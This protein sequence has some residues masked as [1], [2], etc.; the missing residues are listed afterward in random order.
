MIELR[1]VSFA[2]ENA[3][4]VNGL[5]EVS[6]RIPDGQAVLLCGES[7]CGKTTLTRLINGLI[8][9]FYAGKLVG[10]VLLHGESVTNL[11]LHEIALSVGSVFQNPRSQFFNVDTTSELAFACENMGLARADIRSRVMHATKALHLQ[12]L[13]D[14]ISSRCL[15]GRNRSWPA[16][17]YPRWSR[18]SM[19]W[20]S[21]PQTS[22]LLRFAICGP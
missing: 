10:E 6:L 7:G 21:P 16:A 12:D 1:N 15:E 4:A 13:L 9:H 14:A 3:D 19:C 2:Y 22:I 18:K 17:R 8:P 20:M 5:S 11:P